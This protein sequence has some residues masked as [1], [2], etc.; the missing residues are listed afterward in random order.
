VSEPDELALGALLLGDL[1]D[2]DESGRDLQ[3]DESAEPGPPRHV[4]I[5]RR[6]D[7]YAVMT[8]DL[9]GAE[10]ETS[11]VATLEEARALGERIAADERREAV[12]RW[13]KPWDPAG[14]PLQRIDIKAD[15][16]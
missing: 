9:G 7:G 1:T 6:S 15:S 8:T 12:W 3:V 16:R 14:P 11:V 5:W 13:T 4:L 2:A 10:I